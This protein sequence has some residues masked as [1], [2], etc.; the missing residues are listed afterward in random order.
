MANNDIEYRTMQKQDI[1]KALELWQNSD[2][3]HLHSNGEESSEGI[4]RYLER[5]PGFSFVAVCHDKII[6]AVL[7]G[8]DGRRGFINHLAVAPEHR[9]RG[10]GKKLISLAEEQLSGAGIR[11]E[12]LFVLCENENAQKFYE[13]IGWR[14]ETAVKTYS[15]LLKG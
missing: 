10:I 13:H 6:G 15:K 7:C 11:K 5:N 4:S 1:S 8:H 12:A 3:V 14:E 9:H 2:G